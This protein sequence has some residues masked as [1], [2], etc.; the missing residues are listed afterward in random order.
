[1]TTSET[2]LVQPATLSRSQLEPAI[3]IGALIVLIVIL[4]LI[5]WHITLKARQ[6]SGLG[7]VYTVVVSSYVLTR[8]ALAAAYRTPKDRGIEPGVAIVVPAFNEGE[9][10]ARTIHACM[11]LDYPR[12]KLQMVVVNDGSSDDTWEHMTSAAA[13]YTPG[14]VHCVDL[15]R[16][17]GKRVAMTAGI[18]ATTADILVFIDSDSMPEPDGV[19]KLVQLFARPKVGAGSGLTLVRNADANALTKMQQARYYVSFQLLKTAESVLGAV[20][21]NPGCFSAYR[22]EAVVPLLPKWEHQTWWGTEC[23]FGDDR[24]LTNMVMR[25]G[26]ESR[27]HDGAV[28]RT[29]VPEQYRKFFRQ[30]LRWK[31]SWLREGPK[32]LGHMW[33]TRPP[34][35]PSLAIQTVAGLMS[36]FVMVYNLLIHSAATGVPPTLYP[37]ALY[38]IASSYGLLYRS[39]RNDG[40]WKWA[41]IGTFFYIAFSPQLLWAAIRVRATSWGTRGAATPLPAPPVP[42]TASL[43]P[44]QG[45]AP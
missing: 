19:R 37:I 29:D 7:V 21:C 23:T 8:F 42:E 34:A 32:L 20:T 4:S 16:N 3:R 13:M 44:D 39:Q 35:F 25:A 31:K 17:Q 5:G 38:M 18:L 6:I 26:W 1:M 24:A 36:P 28:A 41:I 12:E 43:S 9:A 2:S 40:L 22:R 33:R 30:Q 14:A 11:S 27:Y 15:G 45:S 10:V